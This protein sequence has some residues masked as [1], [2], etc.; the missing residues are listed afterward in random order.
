MFRHPSRLPVRR[1]LYSHGLYFHGPSAR[2]I[3]FLLPNGPQPGPGGPGNPHFSSPP[4][5][6]PYPPPPWGGPVVPPRPS[7]AIPFSPN[8]PPFAQTPPSQGWQGLLQNLTNSLSTIDLPGLITTAQKWMGFF[9]QVGSVIKQAAPLLQLIQGLSQGFAANGYDDLLSEWDEEGEKKNKKKR[10]N[11]KKAK[12][13]GKLQ[14]KKKRK[15]KKL[16]S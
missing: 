11:Q 10:S 4:P 3:G 13:K 9:N 8:N 16:A 2:S 1:P 7:G 5:S 12:S 6:N 15:V 14:N